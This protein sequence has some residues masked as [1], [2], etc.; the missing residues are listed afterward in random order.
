MIVERL[1]QQ[2][3]QPF[4]FEGHTME[5]TASIGHAR[6]PEDGQDIDPLLEAA[7]RSMYQVKRTRSMRSAQPELTQKHVF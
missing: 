2:T 1:S 6:F 4:R 3:D 7:D 5:L